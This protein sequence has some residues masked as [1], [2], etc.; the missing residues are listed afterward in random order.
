M[1]VLEHSFDRRVV[2]SRPW[3]TA[4]ETKRPFMPQLNKTEIETLDPQQLCIILVVFTCRH[5]SVAQGCG[6][7]LALGICST[8]VA[9]GNL[10]F[11]R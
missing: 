7:P 5:S 11:V 8:H 9:L 10:A 3:L 2:I 6:K 4:V 1:T